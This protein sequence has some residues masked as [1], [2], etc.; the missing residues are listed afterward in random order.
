VRRDRRGVAPH[1][2]SALDEGFFCQSIDRNLTRARCFASRAPSPTRRE[3]KK[4]RGPSNSA[5]LNLVGDLV[6]EA[7]AA[8]GEDHFGR[9]LFGSQCRKG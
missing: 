7:D 3:G 1:H 8:E 6:R 4:G 5:Q 9:Q 2:S